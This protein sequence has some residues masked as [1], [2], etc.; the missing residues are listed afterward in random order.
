M[1]LP[2]GL[3]VYGTAAADKLQQI[4][5]D[6]WSARGDLEGEVLALSRLMTTFSL[7]AVVWRQ[8]RQMYERQALAAWL[9]SVAA[10]NA[11]STS[12]G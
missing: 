7:S 3:T 11:Q 6:P 5:L 1:V 9:G 10:R 8:C 2:S 12:G 4:A